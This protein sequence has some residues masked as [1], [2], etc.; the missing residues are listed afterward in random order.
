MSPSIRPVPLDLS[1][2]KR[3][4]VGTEL[5]SWLPYLVGLSLRLKQ[6][7][8]NLRGRRFK[9]IHEQLDEILADLRVAVDD[10]AER[11]VTIGGAADGL[12]ATVAATEGFE[13]MPADLLG[14]E[15]VIDVI[16]DDLAVVS[17]RG[18]RCLQVVGEVDPISEDLAITVIGVL[19]KH[20]WL[21]RSQ[22]DQT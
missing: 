1:T 22:R 5:Q 17:Q 12:P 8:W 7:H 20:H 18:R 9:S 6:A 4:S 14:V 16:G 11:I 19:E 13:P 15:T 2:D 3:E 21:L 10:V